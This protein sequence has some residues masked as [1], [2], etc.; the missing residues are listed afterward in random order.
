MNWFSTLSLRERAIILICS[1][2]VASVLIVSRAVPAYRIW[3]DSLIE[4]E[5]L[6]TASLRRMQADV[7][8]AALVRDSVGAWRQRLAS[9][10]ARTFPT[11]DALQAAAFATRSNTADSVG[12]ALESVRADAYSA[13]AMRLCPASECLRTVSMRATTRGGTDETLAFVRALRERGSS[14]AVSELSIQVQNATGAP[15]PSARL[16]GGFTFRVLGNVDAAG[17]RLGAKR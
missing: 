4:R 8:H 2:F 10:H 5:A 1:S 14:I 7:A 16:E 15:V 12:L 13:D 17:L 9:T 3:V 6:G 11:L